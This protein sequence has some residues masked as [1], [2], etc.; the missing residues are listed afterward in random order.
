VVQDLQPNRGIMMPFAI[1]RVLSGAAVLLVATYYLLASIPFSF[2]HFLQFPHFWWMP[3]FIRTH[4]LVMAAG[5]GGLLLTMRGLPRAN[6]AR[7]RILTLAGTSIT[8]WMA[9]TAWVPVLQTYENAAFL[10]FAAV[11]L[12]GAAGFETLQ[13]APTHAPDGEQTTSSV[14][15]AVVAAVLA[16]AL[17]LA[18]SH[19][20]NAG[21]AGHP[22]EATAV[23]LVS[24]LG[25]LA[26]FVAIVAALRSIRTLGRA[27]GWTPETTSLAL[28]L[29]AGLIFG[30]ILYRTVFTAL[31]M[32]PLRSAATAGVL[33]VSFTLFAQSLLVGVVRPGVSGRLSRPWLLPLGLLLLTPVTAALLPR[34][35]VLADWGFAL[36][37]LLVLT[38]W[39]L[40]FSAVR[41]WPGWRPRAAAAVVIL[42]A[43]APLATGVRIDARAGWTEPA[44]GLDLPLAIERHAM[45]DTSMMV[46]LD[47]ARPLA[48]DGE[49]FSQ[50]RQL[51][52]RVDDPALRPVP[53]RL[54]ADAAKAAA[55]PPHIFIVVVDSLRP[56]YLGAYNPRVDF[57]PN[58]T[59]FARESVVMRRAFT[60]YT[61]TALSQP[62]LWAG[63]LIQRAMYVKPF[64][65]V[66]NLERLLAANNYR[67]YVSVDAILSTILSDRSRIRAL[68]T[69]LTHPDREDQM[70]RFDLCSSVDELGE[71]LRQDAAATE[72][73]FFYT[74]PQNLHIR[75]I[76]PEGKNK[77]QSTEV[78]GGFFK[79]ARDALK[80]V[81]ACFG[82]LIDT[83][84]NRGVYENSIVVLTSD[85]GDAYGEG[86]RW[87]HAFYMTPETLRIP[88]VMR[89]PTAVGERFAVHDNEVVVLTDV[90]PTL[91]KLLG[92]EP[93]VGSSL[94]GRSFVSRPGE[95]W[96]GADRRQLL[97]QSS[98]SRIFGLLDGEARWLYT[99]NANE[100]R[101]QFYDLTVDAVQPR[102]LPAR[103]RVT[104]RKALADA[105]RQVGEHY[106]PEPA[107]THD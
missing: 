6:G 69:H 101:E 48:T 85:H 89:L 11:A 64:S 104:F 90:V 60:S 14:R 70:F 100:A 29:C 41:A 46:L 106:A 107:G 4:P 63:G 12:L 8:T 44:A 105:M 38:T 61:G 87:G 24:L 97:V 3:L 58:I 59:A 96:A 47:L 92:Y 33:G 84:R 81:D 95:P 67:Q 94:L 76:A 5:M 28:R 23:A 15:H 68:D 30:A 18:L 13:A 65:A 25:H 17:F 91:Y 20:P 80:H 34:M 26:L 66:N 19:D 98:Y 55:A 75:V 21:G 54:V 10:S 51:G 103:D 7:L 53:L 32:S 62:S 37:K 22:L 79:P 36:Q 45:T 78:E 77:I 43:A 52:D 93:A 86:G 35:L 72:P 49:Y 16:S 83:L 56:D 73:I 82:R 31:T 50:L 102:S 9:V 57:T 2:Y 1:A 40:C 39:G 88:I 27:L 71:R 99:A 42:T 74:Q